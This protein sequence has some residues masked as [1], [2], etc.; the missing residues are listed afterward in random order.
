M[1][2]FPAVLVLD[3]ILTSFDIYRSARVSN[4][5]AD[6]C[7][8]RSSDDF[9]EVIQDVGSPGTG[10]LPNCSLSLA[11]GDRLSADQWPSLVAW[12]AGLSCQ[13][14]LKVP[15]QCMV[16]D[17]MDNGFN[18]QFTNA[19]GTVKDEVTKN[20]SQQFLLYELRRGTPIP[21]TVGIEKDGENHAC[22][23]PTG[24]NSP[25]SNIAPGGDAFVIDVLQELVPH[26][27]PFAVL[28][29]AG[30]GYIWPESFPRDSEL[31][32]IRR[33]VQAVVLNGQADMAVSVGCLTEAFVAHTIPWR[34]YFKGILSVGCRF[35]LTCGYDDCLMNLALTKALRFALSCDDMVLISDGSQR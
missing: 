6:L 7:T 30:S 12:H 18:E 2:E 22:L 34:S 15:R 5:E 3:G 13:T 29:M 14:K 9:P 10:V 24:G 35:G 16:V 28:K 31:F 23:Y 17:I 11:N 32:P 4:R 20:K 19:K 1:S 21:S 8:G 26:W 27:R 33:W 25:V